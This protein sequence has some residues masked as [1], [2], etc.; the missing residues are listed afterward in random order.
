MG[1]GHVGEGSAGGGPEGVGQIAGQL[2]LTG[3]VQGHGVGGSGLKLGQQSLGLLPAVQALGTEDLKPI[4]MDALNGASGAASIIAVAD[5]GTHLDIPGVGIVGE[6][7]LQDEDAVAHVLALGIFHAGELVGLVHVAVETLDDLAAVGEG[8]LVGA[9]LAAVGACSLNGLELCVGDGNFRAKL[10]LGICLPVLVVILVGDNRLALFQEV[11]PL[12]AAAVHGLQEG[13][14]L[15]LGGLVD[16]QHGVLVGVL[17][18]HVVRLH[19]LLQVAQA[20]LEGQAQVAP[21]GGVVVGIVL[22]IAVNP[23]AAQVGD[24][25]RL[26]GG[27]VGQLE[28]K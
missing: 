18:Q 22:G 15:L 7:I 10:V 28:D 4:V 27:R 16:L 1:G 21:A 26:V 9:S 23:V 5:A 8:N 24:S 25:E 17:G 11:Y 2:N 14:S 19:G 6:G 13:N 12:I 20:V 3:L